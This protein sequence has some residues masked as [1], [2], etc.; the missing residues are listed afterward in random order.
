MA[1]VNVLLVPAGNLSSFL[2][3]ASIGSGES[4]QRSST[5]DRSRDSPRQRGNAGSA[6]GRLSASPPDCARN[7]GLPSREPS[8]RREEIDRG[9]ATDI[10]GL[11]ATIAS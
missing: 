4:T 10:R 3:P 6:S 2:S 5:L 1:Y 8:T 7:R 11:G 9:P